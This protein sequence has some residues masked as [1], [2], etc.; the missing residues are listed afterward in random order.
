MG[1]GGSF[2]RHNDEDDGVY[3]YEGSDGVIKRIPIEVKPRGRIGLRSVKSMAKPKSGSLRSA[4]SVDLENAEVEKIRR[5]F[6]MYRLNKENDLANMQKKVQKFETEN[7]RLRAELQTMQKMCSKRLEERDAALKAEHQ[8]VVRAAA[9]GSDRDKIQRQFKI[10]RETKES[11]LQNLLKAHRQFENTLTKSGISFLDDD[12]TSRLE[13]PIG[14][15]HPGNWWTALE[16]EPSMGSTTQLHTPMFRG[17]EFAHGLLEMDGPYINVNKDDW[18]AVA[19]SLAQ[20]FTATSD[21]QP[22]NVIHVYLSAPRDVHTEVNIFIEKFVPD[23]QKLCV[24]EGCFLIA[25][26]MP[27]PSATGKD[28]QMCDHVMTA[29]R[30]RLDQCTVFIAFLGHQ[31]DS[32]TE[33][34]FELGCLRDQCEK[35]AIICLKNSR[36]TVS[37]ETDTLLRRVR[38]RRCIKVLEYNS[39]PEEGAEMARTELEKIIK[40][41]LGLDQKQQ[42]EIPDNICQLD[43]P[44]ILCG[45]GLWDAHHDHEQLEAMTQALRSTCELGF[46]KYYEVLNA[47]VSAAGPLPPLLVTGPAGSGRSLLLAKWMELQQQKTPATLILS[48]F[49]GG[50]TSCSANS[51]IMLRRLT[52]QLMQQVT[53]P[54]ALTC[55]PLR[56]V[57]EFPKWLEKVSSKTNGG[58]ILILDSIDRLQNGETEL[59]WLL[60]P[61][62]VDSRVIVTVQGDKCPQSWK[63]WPTV[64]I[65]DL[66]SKSR[67][68]LLRAELASLG[69][70]LTTGQEHSILEHCDECSCSP[71]YISLLAN[72]IARCAS[73]E[74][75]EQHLC[76]FLE[77]SDAVQLFMAIIDCLRHEYENPDTKGSLK[78]ILKYVYASRN[79]LSETELFELIPVMTHNFWV[80]LEIALLDHFVL[81]YRSG[82]LVF[83]HEQVWQAVQH[84][85]FADDGV[86]LRSTQHLLM[87][88]F[89]RFR[90]P[91]EVSYR[92]A[93]ELPWLNRQLVEKEAL[94]DN[95]LNL[96]IFVQLYGRG[97]CAELIGY[98]QF[99][100]V[101][102]NTMAHA[103]VTATKKMEG[104]ID[105]TSTF[106][107]L[108]RIADVY[109]AVGRFLRDL[110]LLNE[111][112]TPLQ[113]ALE[114]R[115]TALDPDHPSVAQSLHQLAGLHAQQAKFSVAEALYKQAWEIYDGAFGPDHCMAA[116]EMDALAI[117][118]QKQGK[119]ELAE[120]L[121]KRATSIR[122]KCRLPRV[123]PTHLR[124]ADPLR[125]RTLQLEELAMAADSLDLARTLNEIGVLYYLQ[126]SIETA[127]SF[128]KRS[129]EMRESLVGPE[130][131]DFAQSLSNL[132][133]L[134]NDRRQYDK[135]EPLYEQALDIR[136]KHFS[137]DHPNVGSIIKNLAMMYKKMGKLDKA[138]VLY[139]EMVEIRERSFGINHPAVATVLVNLA[140]LHS[141][142]GNHTLALPLYERAQ[143]IYEDSL[144]PNHPRVAETLR[145][146]ALLKYDQGE[147]ETAA[148]LYKRATEIKESDP[149]IYPVRSPSHHG[150][151]G[152]LY[153][154][155]RKSRSRAS[156]SG[157]TGSTLRNSHTLQIQSAY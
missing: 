144:G 148:K 94:H 88:Y 75:V 125:K 25:T 100:C 27:Q 84:K 39:D 122:R 108:P 87:D 128:F 11:E 53:S 40:V 106:V 46:E 120:P 17:P 62:P 140:V 85:Y 20:S 149:S 50:P 135:A 24:T 22:A 127:E 141:Q 101:D 67:M 99:L 52:A 59:S 151:T 64:E 55:D 112:L 145:N 76:S 3:E 136:R 121:H 44:E 29:C 18:T 139:I 12:C 90:R 34:E 117:V 56:L 31:M 61:L 115:E 15:G 35:S 91:G 72:D 19:A 49:V 57:D 9:F 13:L 79:G 133:G 77:C 28:S 47:H 10:F 41:E 110:A 92:V 114:I 130:H 86:M 51:T 98:W 21:T 82:L 2:L 155:V 103:Y 150:S 134:Y 152:D 131:P 147:Y 65:E 6:E 5:D 45:G 73:D 14:N 97:R 8:A 137:A 43:S 1:T 33:T 89:A 42:M 142:Q 116:K 74:L 95:L 143:K 66:T 36:Q 83:A 107:T 146:L 154:P 113:R 26:F 81:V 78:K 48:H 16:S 37:S 118:Y 80:P 119:L 111:A 124:V 102:K 54:P 71:L 58:I 93:D 109:E 105:Q 156:S 60:D 4:L 23:L 104:M 138:K 32:F 132:A 30:R 129:L 96:C 68:E 7:R 38:E 157:D 123:T 153:P 63:S 69:K 126:N 70:S